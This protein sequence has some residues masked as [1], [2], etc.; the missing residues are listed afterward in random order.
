VVVNPAVP[1]DHPVVRA[2]AERGVPLTTEIN[3]FL[4]RTRAF[5][6][7]VTGTKGK[8]TTSSILATLLSAG[9]RR[10]HLGGNVGRS[11][12]ASVDAL[13]PEDCVVLELSSFQLWWTH[14]L[15]RSPRVAVVTNLF[16]DHLD[17]HG[18][19]E[20]YLASKRAILD[21]QGPED[22]AVLPADDPAVAAAGFPAAGRGRR[23]LYGEGGAYR[24]E[25][26]RARGPE[27]EIADLAA[28]PLWGA[29]NRRNALAALAA[30]LQ[31]PGTTPATL[32]RGLAEV[33]PLPHRLE[34]VAEVEGV[35]YV[36]DSNATNP[37]STI[38]ALEAVPRPAVLLLGGKDKGIDPGPLLEAVARRARAVVGIGT[39]G[40][41]LVARLAGRLP[42]VLG[43]P[44]LESAVAEAA[45]L[46][47]P[48]DAVLL[49]PA[50]S[51]LDQ[52]P[53]FAVRGER[54]QAAV[55]AR[56]AAGTPPPRPAPKG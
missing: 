2:A 50:Y 23:V 22:A 12:L 55:R 30:A 4:A 39:S 41:A 20:H 47:R 17:R 40:P 6:L 48:G 13:G 45:R 52:F 29:H 27:G 25:G 32:A 16:G 42:T 33:R 3:L 15:R 35:L 37:Q 7:G 8:S 18:T 38:Q 56:A 1:F 28:L 24:L 54:F 36:D 53:S 31:V 10:T 11:L 44:D 34:P 19:M 49:S 43:G 5:V 14:R 51:S 26:T 46:A 21:Y 9:G